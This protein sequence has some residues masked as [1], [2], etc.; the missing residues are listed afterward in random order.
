MSIEISTLPNGLTVAT[1]AMPWLGSAT[2][3]I[4]VRAGA[5]HER[6]EENGIA[7]FLEHMA[8]KGTATRSARDI[9]EQIEAVGGYI[10]AYTSREVTAYYARVLGGDVELALDILADI[11]V[12]PAFDPAE[13]ETE[14]GVILQEIGQSRDTPDDIVFD[15]LQEAAF[16]DQPLGRPILGTPERVR[17]FTREDFRAFTARHY[18]PE[19]MILAAAGAVSHEAV[20]AK[21]EALLGG[22]PPRPAPAPEPARFAGGERREA[23][24]LEQAH[25]ALGFEGPAQT[26][27]EFWAGQAMNI[28]LGGGMSSRLFQELRERRGLCY[29]V[30]SQM[31]AWSDSGLITVYAGTSA[32][33]LPEL[34]TLTLDEIRRAASDLTEAEIARARAQMRSGVVM[35]LES[36]TGRAER[37]ARHLAVWG[38]VIPVEEM[39]DRIDAVDV[40]AA[41]AAAERLCSAGRMAYALCGPEAG[42]P[43]AA[44]MLARLAA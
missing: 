34:L 40:A 16:P 1:E 25:V 19:R 26:A 6:A 17:A 22:L 15:W 29:S 12:N 28:A 3:G 41:R 24:P 2:I 39:L 37:L 14:R 42:G 31:S 20:R 9:A 33:D 18:V 43:G 13:I 5:R 32:E 7:H 35:G 11:L 30:F 21:A 27:P 38:R 8:F 44:E 4:W 10:N 36:A 23:R